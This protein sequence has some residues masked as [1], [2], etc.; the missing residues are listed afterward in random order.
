MEVVDS[1]GLALAFTSFA[2][3]LAREL[4]SFFDS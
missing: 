3:D 2:R 4:M 1:E